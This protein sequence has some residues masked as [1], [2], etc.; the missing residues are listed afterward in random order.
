MQIPMQV[1]FRGM[2]PSV[3]VED[4]IR[5]EVAKLER[6]SERLTS[7]RVVVERSQRRHH[8]GNLFHVRIDLTLP[9]REVLVK[10]EPAEHH[11]HEDVYVAIRDA[12]DAAR[13]RIMDHVRRQ[14]LDVKTHAEATVGRV[15]RLLPGQDHGFLEAADGH[16][17]YFHRNSVLDGGFDALAVGAEVRFVEEAGDKGPQA[18][19]VMPLG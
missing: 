2:K 6:Y 16:E 13:R 7:C 4:R 19:T 9:G 14:R 8:Q 11:A 1:S 12:F 5:K 17:V 18:S 10:R 3:A 15:V